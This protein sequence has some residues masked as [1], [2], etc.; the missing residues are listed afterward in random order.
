MYLTP[1]TNTTSEMAPIDLW[2]SRIKRESRR[3]QSTGGSSL[4]Q[5]N[6]KVTVSLDKERPM[7]KSPLY[8]KY[9]IQ[10]MT[11]TLTSVSPISTT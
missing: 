6:F 11:S 8:D 3:E 2:A 1:N 10:N 4:K 7:S 9:N 5:D